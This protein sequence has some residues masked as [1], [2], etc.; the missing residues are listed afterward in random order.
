MHI[1]AVAEYIWALLGWGLVFIARAIITLVVQIRRRKLASFIFHWHQWLGGIHLSWLPGEY[2][3]FSGWVVTLVLRIITAPDYI[4]AL[5]I[6]ALVIIG[7]FLMAP[8][9]SFHGL[10]NVFSWLVKQ[11]KRRPAPAQ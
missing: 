9:A 11:F 3:L 4:G 7:I 6:L 5:R 1:V 8:M 10:V 2:W